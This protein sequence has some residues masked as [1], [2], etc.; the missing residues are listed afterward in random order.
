[1]WLVV[2]ENKMH[3]GFLVGQPEGTKPLGRTRCKWKDNTTVDLKEIWN[4]GYWV[5]V[6]QIGTS[7]NRFVL[8]TELNLLVP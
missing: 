4:C 2:W 8:N 1:M 7:G 5:Y 3:I 6:A